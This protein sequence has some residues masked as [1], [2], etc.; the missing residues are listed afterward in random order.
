MRV[1]CRVA[2]FVLF[3][4]S[5]CA[6]AH[7]GALIYLDEDFEGSYIFVDR[8]FPVTD[9]TQTQ[10]VAP[11]AQGINLRAWDA[12]YT[13]PKV[14]LGTAEGAVVSTRA[15]RGLKSYC[16]QSGQNLA[17]TP[18]H[19]PFRDADAFR[20]W[21]FALSTDAASVA[22]A[23]DTR[24]GRFDISYSTAGAADLTP[25]V[26]I[27]LELVATGTEKARLTCQNNGETLAHLSGAAND[28]V[29]VSI[30]AQDSI[31]TPTV[32]DTASKWVAF[33][34]LTDT[35]KGPFLPVLTGVHIYVTDGNG[36]LRSSLLRG[37]ALGASWGNTAGRQLTAE[38]G[39]RFAAENGGTL[40]I[41]DLYWD[42]G[43]HGDA[44]RAFDREQA[45]RMD[46][47]S[48][49]LEMPPLLT[50]NAVLQ[51][52]APVPV[53]GRG[54]QGEAIT[55]GFNSQS[56]GVSCGTDGRWQVVLDPMPEGGP[57]DMTITADSPEGDG[58][59]SAPP[60][61]VGPQT[62]VVHNIM[63]GEVWLCSGQSNMAFTV[64]DALNGAAEIAA[65][66]YPNIRLFTVPLALP[67]T[68]DENLSGGNWL[69]CSSKTLP[70]FSAV[71]YFFG[72]DLYQS[73]S[74]A[75]A[76]G[77]INSSVGATRAED[78]TSRDAL[79]ADPELAGLIGTVGF[80]GVPACS[81]FNGMINPLMPYAFRGAIWYQGESNAAQAALY[82]KLFPTMIRDWRTRWGEGDFPFLYVQ[83]PNF[84]DSG[85]WPELREAQLLT[86]STT[87]TAMAVTI[88][89]GVGGNLHPPNKQEVGRRLALAARGK[90]YG[91][92]LTYSG[93]IYRTRAIE[94]DSLRLSFDHTDGGLVDTNGGALNGFTIAGSNGV[95][96]AAQA[97]IDGNTVVVRSPSVPKPRHARYAWADNPPAEL[98]NGAGLP[99]SPFRTDYPRP[100]EGADP[101]CLLY[102]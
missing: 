10:P 63:V 54:M 22:L 67:S 14:Q 6:S 75:I 48:A 59:G 25:D 53:W 47:F 1:V 38:I 93:P 21:Q 74:G 92:A 80:F 83:L 62:V 61:S 28:W 44:E 34:P 78:W 64:S 56:K 7:A 72:R 12:G 36:A 68:P 89:V 19:F 8:N 20:F 16:L 85:L 95:F 76:I 51:R 4:L 84:S 81:L 69:E 27:R 41:D 13:T 15:Y 29:L 99:A 39:W 96:V 87:N 9:S 100:P 91:Q 73:S 42:A 57:Y 97:T 52:Q 45:A 32:Q 26:M 94:G 71:A 86:L 17:V 66:N 40:Y 49:G 82:R 88:D 46:A 24:I 23:S 101:V 90:V 2:F 50:D 18:G 33:D 35:T 30:I 70:T 79:A 55:V 43:A 31:T 3:V 60:R 11:L 98:F 102:E 58:G 65:G 37:D 77:L 5:L